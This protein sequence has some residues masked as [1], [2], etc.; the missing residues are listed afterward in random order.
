[1]PASIDIEFPHAGDSVGLIFPVGGNY[2]ATGLRESKERFGAND[3]IICRV[4][5]A[6]GTTPIGMDFTKPFMMLDP[7]VGVWNLSVTLPPPVP[8]GDY[9]DCVIKAILQVGP[10][11]ATPYP[12]SQIEDVDA[13]PAANGPAPMVGVP[14][15]GPISIFW[16]PP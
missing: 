3:K 12:A 4:F 9:Q 11:T 10:V 15:P 1:M 16:L 8:P 13:S 6:D 14:L 2:D 7:A 5:K